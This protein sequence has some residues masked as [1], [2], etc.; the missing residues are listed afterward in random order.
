MTDVSDGISI[1]RA[2]LI[3]MK[4]SLRVDAAIH[5]CS[6]RHPL[7]R[8]PTAQ[9]STGGATPRCIHV[10]LESIERILKQPQRVSRELDKDG[11]QREFRGVI[12]QRRHVCRHYACHCGSD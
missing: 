9:A 10:S 1:E 6:Y 7:S 2:P 11:I 5:P 4:L 8:Y 3:G 12:L